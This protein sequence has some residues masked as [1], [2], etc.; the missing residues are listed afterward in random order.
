MGAARPDHPPAAD[1]D[2]VRRGPMP[3]TASR[4]GS[5]RPAG[6]A[7]SSG[8]A[9]STPTRALRRG[10]PI[11]SAIRSRRP[12]TTPP[13]RARASTPSTC[14]SRPQTP[15]TSLAFAEALRRAR[16]QRHAAIQGRPAAARA[17]PSA[18]HA[19]R[20]RSTRSSATD[21]RWLGANTDVDGLLAPLAERSTLDG[22]RATIL[23]AGGAARAAAVAL[24]DAG[25]RVTVCARRRRGGRAVAANSASRRR[26]AAGA[27]QLGPAGQRDVGG[28]VSAGGRDAW[29]DARFDGVSST[30]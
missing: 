20:V 28:H 1:S 5:C 3:V 27:G 17:T 14:R 18:R 23:G 6:C 26:H 7:T 11:R 4:P 30:T 21:G 29:P 8:S 13:S 24:V 9:T 2:S 16:R 25:A 22:A 12:C 15:T 19:G 10:R